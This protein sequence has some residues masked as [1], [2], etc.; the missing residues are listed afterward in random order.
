MVLHD[1]NTWEWTPSRGHA[2]LEQ[3]EQGD[4]LSFTLSM[5]VE[6]KRKASWLEL[7]GAPR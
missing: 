3:P 1:G 7:D 6:L 2:S 5:D 4:V